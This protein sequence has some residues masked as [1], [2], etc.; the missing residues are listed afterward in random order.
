[1]D[2]MQLLALWT[3][4]IV[5][6]IVYVNLLEKQISSDLSDLLTQLSLDRVKPIYGYY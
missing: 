6:H 4:L 3:Q 1:M 2:R 5:F